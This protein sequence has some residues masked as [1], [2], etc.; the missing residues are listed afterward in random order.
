MSSSGKDKGEPPARGA[1]RR[2]AARPQGVTGSI[3]SASRPAQR[4]APAPSRSRS[5]S[6]PNSTASRRQP[7]PTSGR[8]RDAHRHPHPGM[9]AWSARWQSTAPGRFDRGWCSRRSPR[10]PGRSVLML[11]L[12][13]VAE[14]RGAAAWPETAAAGRSM[15]RS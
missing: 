6:S 4:P 11:D 3:A 10:V 2:V 1:S 7:V 14:R 5:T 9:L 15:A 13:S 12:G 8:L